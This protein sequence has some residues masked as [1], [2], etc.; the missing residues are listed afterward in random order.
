MLKLTG[1]GRYA[2]IHSKT[3]L[4][5]GKTLLVGS[6]NLSHNSLENNWETLVVVRT[7][8]APLEFRAAFGVLWSQGTAVD[9]ERLEDLKQ[10]AVSSRQPGYYLD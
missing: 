8:S 4:V 10:Q 7:R 5:D 3:A 9:R 6:A 1:R 2:S